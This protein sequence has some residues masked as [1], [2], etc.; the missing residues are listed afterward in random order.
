MTRHPLDQLY[1]TK[2]QLLAVVLTVTGIFALL[3]AHWASSAPDAPSWLLVLPLTD[4]G[5]AI[6]TTGLLAVAFE[7]LDRRDGDARTD[8]RLRRAIQTEAPAIRDAVLD[9][10]AFDPKALQNVASNETLDRI[11]TNALGL[12][13]GDADLAA[14]VYADV[15]DQVV[16]APER[17]H[18]VGIDITLR[19]SSAGPAAGRGSMFEAAIRWEYRVIPAQRTLRF[20]CVS[21]RTE[22]RELLRD[23][24]VTSVWHFEPS[25]TIDASS[26]EAFELLQVT[27]DGK[28]RKIRRTQRRDS[29]ISSVALGDSAITGEAVTISYTYRVLVKRHGHM[30][31]LDLPRPTKGLH[32]RLAYNGAGIRRVNALDYFASTEQARVEQPTDTTHAVDIG[33]DGWLFPRSGV[34]FIWTLEDEVRTDQPEQAA[35]NSVAQ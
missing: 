29:Q 30:L 28:D 13:L 7:Y 1:Q 5:S 32:V 12:R 17:W 9:S 14:E 19:P 6:F 26:P 23:Q 24:A 2:L 20:A 21:D 31:Y 11:A 27:V 15:R 33:F 25:S 35:T 3:L 16:L 18:G 10:F 22:Y 8:A 4:L 34:A